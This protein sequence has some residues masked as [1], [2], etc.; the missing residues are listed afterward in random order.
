MEFVLEVC[1]LA[2]LI[3]NDSYNLLT[4]IADTVEKIRS[5]MFKGD[6]VIPGALQSQLPRAAQLGRMAALAQSLSHAQ[7]WSRAEYAVQKAERLFDLMDVP[8]IFAHIERNIDSINSVADHVD[9][10]YQAD[11][12]EKSNARATL[13]SIGFAAVSIILVILALPS[14][15]ADWMQV[16]DCWQSDVLYFSVLIVG[17]LL[18]FIS[19]GVALV[20][21][22][23]VWRHRKEIAG[24]LAQM[25][26]HM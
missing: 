10:L 13:L 26:N 6:I 14:F 3:E 1:V 24:M 11:L 9:E 25:F 20:F 23:K 2:Q 8:R 21:L 7:F 16:Y 4:H 5:D 12:S 15:W 19:I 18:A 22:V 17:T